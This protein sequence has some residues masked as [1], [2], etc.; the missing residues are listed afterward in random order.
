M[1]AMQTADLA[2]AAL[3]AEEWGVLSFTE[4]RQCGLSPAAV[5]TRCRKGVLHRLYAGVYA[6]GHANPPLEGC[7]L[8]AVKACGD[9]AVLSHFSAA[10]YWDLVDWDDREIEVTI[11]GTSHRAASSRFIFPTAICIYSCRHGTSRRITGCGRRFFTS[12]ATIHLMHR[13]GLW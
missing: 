6:I 9:N 4:L 12:P 13:S 1:T 3:A 5:K 8:A 7:F 2:V 10:A 11:A